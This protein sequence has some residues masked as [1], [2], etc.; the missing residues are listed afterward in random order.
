VGGRTEDVGVGVELDGF[1]EF[2]VHFGLLL[3]DV[4]GQVVDEGV[5]ARHVLG[6]DSPLHDHVLFELHEGVVPLLHVPEHV[7]WLVSL[8]FA[9]VQQ[10]PHLYLR[11]I[12][13]YQVT[14]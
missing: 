2:L 9:P 5:V 1:L 7:H 12:T 11:Y 10:N 13:S 4:L 8:L 3:D 14:T 6:D